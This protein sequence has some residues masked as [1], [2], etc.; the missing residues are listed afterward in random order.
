VEP[1]SR[2]PPHLAGLDLDQ[3]GAERLGDGVV[4][5]RVRGG[6]RARRG[7]P[8]GLVRLTDGR[9]L[10]VVAAALH[11]QLDLV[12]EAREDPGGLRI[13]R[14]QAGRLPRHRVVQAQQ[15]GHHRLQHDPA[16]PVAE[17]LVLRVQPVDDRLPVRRAPVEVG[18]L[19]LDP[20]EPFGDLTARLGYLLLLLV[21]L[22]HAS[23]SSPPGAAAGG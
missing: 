19:C 10:Q 11:G 2:G 20:A 16:Q 1:G 13:D 6:H 9:R 18:Q 23:P 14:H 4:Q 17:L 12:G 8:P 15:V 7:V 5:R 3:A 21:P 22:V